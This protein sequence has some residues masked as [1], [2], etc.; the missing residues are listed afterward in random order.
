MSPVHSRHAPTRRSSQTDLPT[1]NDSNRAGRSI[2][3]RLA[4]GFTRSVTS[5]ASSALQATFGAAALLGIMLFSIGVLGS[6]L[7]SD[8]RI[9]LS[10]PSGAPQ[11]LVLAQS[12]SLTRYMPDIRTR[13]HVTPTFT[14]SPTPPFTPTP[15]PTPTMLAGLPS[16][17]S[18]A[19]P[20]GISG[21]G[22]SVVALQNVTDGPKPRRLDDLAAWAQPFR[23]R[24]GP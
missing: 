13:G 22:D 16:A 11:S 1:P 20:A 2:H 21:F 17:A 10:D 23:P 7:R 4:S 18:M 15:T 9:E 6:D 14:P 8:L 3:V 12:E 19:A 24:R 5:V